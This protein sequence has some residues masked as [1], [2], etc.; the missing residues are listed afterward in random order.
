[1]KEKWFSNMNTFSKI[2]FLIFIEIFYEFSLKFPKIPP[3]LK[4]KRN[5]SH[6]NFS[7]LM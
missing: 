2:Q 4:K 6:R 5:F 7:Q 3:K 1:M